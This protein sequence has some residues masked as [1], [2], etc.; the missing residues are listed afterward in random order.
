[1]GWWHTAAVQ[2]GLD[3]PS[4]ERAPS[5]QRHTISVDGASADSCGFAPP[6]GAPVQPFGAPTSDADP[7]SAPATAES[8]APTRAPSRSADLAST[9]ADE[10]YASLVARI[11]TIESQVAAG[12]LTADLDAGALRV[13]AAPEPSTHAAAGAQ[14]AVSAQPADAA[15]VM[16]SS[17]SPS[18]SSPSSRPSPPSAVGATLRTLAIVALLA[19]AGIVATRGNG[20]DSK[21]AAV[22]TGIS[23]GELMVIASDVTAAIQQDS[24]TTNAS[25]AYVRESGVVLMVTTKGLLPS[26]MA[27]WID[28][29]LSP[30]AAQLAGL[31]S[32]E[33]VLVAMHFDDAPGFDRLVRM[34]AGGITDP[35][36]WVTVPIAGG[37]PQSLVTGGDVAPATTVAV[38][39]TAQTSPAAVDAV[40]PSTSDP[41]NNDATATTVAADSGGTGNA[42]TGDVVNEEFSSGDGQWKALAGSWQVVDGVYQQTDGLGFDL[43][44]RLDTTVP[45]SYELEVKMRGIDGAPINAGVVLAQANPATREGAVVIDITDNGG[46]IRWG[47]YAAVGGAY[48]FIGGAALPALLDPAQWHTLRVIVKGETTIV[49]VD[50]EQIGDAGLVGAGGVGLV[51]SQSTVEFDDLKVSGV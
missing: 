21:V 29:L 45:A 5:I 27:A 42:A 14:A 4:I 49:Y 23:D 38:Q 13:D 41:A 7:T 44:S 16:V 31:P 40:A 26:E 33:G 10:I 19:V 32:G 43:I 24:A 12:A 47:K 51:V 1:M 9:S 11:T 36:S 20:M 25:S 50:D 30:F 28:T 8:P 2:F 22:S 18:P 3:D 35:A 6:A 46:Y 15:V 39:Q 37:L 17:P 48:E 34:E